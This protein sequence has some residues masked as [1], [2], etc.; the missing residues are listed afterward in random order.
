[1]WASVSIQRYAEGP[2]SPMPNG[3]GRLVGCKRTP[4]DRGRLGLDM[5]FLVAKEAT[6]VG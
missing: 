5:L 1:M 2:R 3:P 4:D 6:E